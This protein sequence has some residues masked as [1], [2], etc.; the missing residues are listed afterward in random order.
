MMYAEPSGLGFTVGVGAGVVA[1]VTDVAGDECRPASSNTV[2]SRVTSRA[3]A[4]MKVAGRI[5]CS[6]AAIGG[7]M[8]GSS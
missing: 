4:L 2:T 7:E 5:S 3:P 1:A 8:F 6:G